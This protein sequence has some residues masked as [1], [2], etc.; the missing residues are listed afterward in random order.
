MDNG[1]QSNQGRATYPHI[2]CQEAK[3]LFRKDFGF[4]WTQKQDFVKENDEKFSKNE[5]DTRILRPGDF[6]LKRKPCQDGKEFTLHKCKA[7]K[8][9]EEFQLM[10]F[11]REAYGQIYPWEVNKMFI[12][13]RV[14]II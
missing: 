8:K 5:K 13:G 4:I 12:F 9:K 3:W 7:V 6:K 10:K 14:D 2:A 1:E 11:T